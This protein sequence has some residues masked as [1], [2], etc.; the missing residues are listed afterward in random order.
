MTTTTK[1]TAEAG[2]GHV[3]GE[4]AAQLAL[5]AEIEEAVASGAG[6]G[7]VGPL[8]DHLVQH[9]NAHFL[10]EQILM[11]NS[12]YAAY[13]Q[14]VLEHDLLMSRAREFLADLG[15]GKTEDARPFVLNLRNWLVVHMQTTDAAFE[16]YLE[17]QAPA[18]P[19]EG[20]EVR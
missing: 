19:D 16:T 14:H 10:S 4:H 18:A 2:F 15:G 3:G 11:R 7:V 5:L 17:G 8:L 6:P 1:P 20:S 13:D 9:A 12:A